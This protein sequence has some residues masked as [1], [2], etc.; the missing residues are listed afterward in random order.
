MNTMNSRERLREMGR[1]LADKCGIR[2][3]A[4]GE[5]RPENYYVYDHRT[6]EPLVPTDYWRRPEYQ[7]REQR[8]P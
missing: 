8:K 3:L 4:P 2:L 7:Q 6:G 1:R 5:K